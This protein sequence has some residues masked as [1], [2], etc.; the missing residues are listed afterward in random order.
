MRADFCQIC[1]GTSSNFRRNFVVVS[2]IVDTIHEYV[3][4][5]DRLFYIF[6]EYLSDLHRI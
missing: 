3:S 4:N 1:V 6:G 2:N 5:V